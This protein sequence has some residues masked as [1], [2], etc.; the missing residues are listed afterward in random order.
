LAADTDHEIRADAAHEILESLAS[1][2]IEPDA[3]CYRLAA[4]AFR[5][6]GEEGDPP[7]ESKRLS[8]IADRLESGVATGGAER[9]GGGVDGGGGV[10][11]GALGDL[12]IS[13]TAGLR[14]LLKEAGGVAFGLPEA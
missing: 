7:P 1:E 3:R 11:D 2:G 9:G 14:E 5:N 4:E 6:T 12:D 13:G 8:E 10:L